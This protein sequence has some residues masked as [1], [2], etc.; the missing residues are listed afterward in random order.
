MIRILFICISLICGSCAPTSK[1]LEY[2]SVTYDIG[3]YLRI[4]SPRSNDLARWS[5]NPKRNGLDTRNIRDKD[6]LRIYRNFQKTIIVDST[7]RIVPAVLAMQFGEE[8]DFV[9][10]YYMD[11]EVDADAMIVFHYED[12]AKSNDSLFISVIRSNQIRYNSFRATADSL[13]WAAVANQIREFQQQSME[14]LWPEI[15]KRNSAN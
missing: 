5:E 12:A 3:E 2:V 1:E 9:D 11:N 6:S 10:F 4:V 15:L 7:A 14:R 8:G 13:C